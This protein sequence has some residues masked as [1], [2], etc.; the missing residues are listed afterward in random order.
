MPIADQLTLARIACAPLVVRAL[1]ASISPARLLGDRGLLRRD[2]DRLV[3]REDRPPL[4]DAR[5][6]SARCSTRS[7]T[8]CSCSATLIVLLDQGVFPAWMVAAIVARELLVS[9][10]RLAALE[11]GVVIAARDLGKLKTW[12]QAIA[13]A[14]G[15][16]AAAG[17]WS[18]ER[19]VVAAA[20]RGR[21][22]VGLRAR[23]RA[24]GA[25]RAARPGSRALRGIPLTRVIR[26]SPREDHLFGG[27]PC[28]KRPKMGPCGLFLVP[29]PSSGSLPRPRSANALTTIHQRERRHDEAV[30]ASSSSNSITVGSKHR[31]RLTCS[32]TSYSPAI[33]PF[34]IGDRRPDRLLRATCSSRSQSVPRRHTRKSTTSAERSRHLRRR[35]RARHRCS[36]TVHDG[37]RNLTCTIGPSSPATSGYG[38]GQHVKITAQRR[39]RLDRPGD[40]SA[41][42][43][44]ELDDDQPT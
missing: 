24:L 44:D 18:H 27:A 6:R 21:A 41:A 11:R 10:L 22:H 17:A 13:A 14:V 43:A 36:I 7:P 9:G 15:G 4:R 26:R 8:R 5:P 31:P 25:E 32:L 16:L 28:P 42:A 19:L 33:G 2:V 3:R 35:H 20:R 34:A 37:D 30:I 38:V 29:W 39:P 1:R 40:E 12:S 23:L